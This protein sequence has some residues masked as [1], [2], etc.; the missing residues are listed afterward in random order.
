MFSLRCVF[1]DFYCRIKVG[2][3]AIQGAFAEHVK[4]LNNA[5]KE[6]N[7]SRPEKPIHANIREIRYLNEVWRVFSQ[8]LSVLQRNVCIKKN[9]LLKKVASQCS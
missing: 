6:L 1:T 2:A 8:L 9:L 3:L 4:S 7:N 5:V